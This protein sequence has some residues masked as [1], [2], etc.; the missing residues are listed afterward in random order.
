MT[1]KVWTP[2]QVTRLIAG[3]HEDIEQFSSGGNTLD[4]E[5][6]LDL[7][8]VVDALRAENERLHTRLTAAEVVLDGLRESQDYDTLNDLIAAYDAAWPPL[9]SHKRANI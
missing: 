4:R 1:S 5:N 9:V 6:I 7:I 8:S 3:I 2:E